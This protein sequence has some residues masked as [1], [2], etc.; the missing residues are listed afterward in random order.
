MLRLCKSCYPHIYH[1]FISGAELRNGDGINHR[2][3]EKCVNEMDESLIPP[4]K[5]TYAGA[6]RISEVVHKPDSIA[7]KRRCSAAAV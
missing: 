3:F 2:F 6:A 7:R 5:R 1:S 4:S